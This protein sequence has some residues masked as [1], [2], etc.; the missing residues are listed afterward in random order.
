VV[1]GGK[2]S[3]GK[4]KCPPEERVMLGNLE[5]TFEK[6]KVRCRAKSEVQQREDIKVGVSWGPQKI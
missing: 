4:G 1:Q 6:K 5:V 2:V 3:P